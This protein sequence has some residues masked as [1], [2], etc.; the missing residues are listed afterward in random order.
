MKKKFLALVLTLAM[1]LSLVPVTALAT[2]GPPDT[3]SGDVV[4]GHY[5]N[6]GN[7]ESDKPENA[8]PDSLK[9]KVTVDKT[10]EKVADNQYEVTLTVQMKHKTEEVQPGAAA[11]VLV[12]DTSGSM[13][14]CTDP[15]HTHTE[16]ILGNGCGTWNGRTVIIDDGMPAVEK[17]GYVEYTTFVLGNGAIDFC[18]VGATVPYEMDRN[19]AKNGGQ[20]TLYSRQRKLFAPRGISFTKK[21]LASQSPTNTELENG[22]NWELVKDA[23]GNKRIN[24]KAIPIA[25]IISKG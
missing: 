1:V 25:R 10:A 8:I 6:D 24:H 9:G 7:W 20:T 12:I 2:D 16:D 23:T 18:N 4:Y 3:A 11:T 15:S 13:D 21:S 19:P 14:Y 17:E 5:T 22:T